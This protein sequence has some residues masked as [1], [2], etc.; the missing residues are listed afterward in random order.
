MKSNEQMQWQEV[1]NAVIKLASD[2]HDLVFIGGVAVYVHMINRKDEQAKGFAEYSHDVD[3]C[4]SLPEFGDMRDIEVVVPNRRLNKHQ[5]TVGKVEV[6]VYVEHGNR[7]AVPYGDLRAAAVE[8]EQIR[9]ACLE[10][11]L[12]LKL[13][14]AQDRWGTP[15]GAKDLRDIAKLGWAMAGEVKKELLAPYLNEER[16]G[17]LRDTARSTAFNEVALGNAHMAK[18]IRGNFDAFMRAVD[19]RSASAPR[20]R[21]R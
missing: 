21:H 10:H 2:Y 13:D 12:I 5:I 14:A 1:W 18:A 3:L 8:Y 16:L 20:P 6:D 19:G 11:L 7:L 17:V 15:K 4:I 9:V